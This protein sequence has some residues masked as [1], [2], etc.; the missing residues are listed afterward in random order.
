VDLRTPDERDAAAK[1]VWAEW[2][3]RF[4]VLP[5]PNHRWALRGALQGFIGE[6]RLWDAGQPTDLGIVA[7]DALRRL[8]QAGKM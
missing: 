7:V 6:G 2:Q 3:R 1:R 8:L 4:K 5:T